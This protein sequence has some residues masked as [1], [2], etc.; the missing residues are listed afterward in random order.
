MPFAASGVVASSRPININVC[1]GLDGRRGGGDGGGQR[2]GDRGVEGAFSD[3]KGVLSAGVMYAFF[4]EIPFLSWGIGRIVRFL[5]SSYF[6]VTFN[7]GF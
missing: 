2:G 5:K 6:D 7:K 3:V 1:G 4:A